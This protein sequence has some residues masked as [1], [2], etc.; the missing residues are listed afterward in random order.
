MKNLFYSFLVLIFIFACLPSDSGGRKP[1]PINC[2]TNAD[3]PKDKICTSKD[4]CAECETTEECSGTLVC[5]NYNCVIPGTNSACSSDSHCASES[6]KKKCHTTLNECVEC[7]YN[8]SGEDTCPN[9][10]ECKVDN[11]CQ[12]ITGGG[13]GVYILGVDCS[14]TTTTPQICRYSNGTTSRICKC[15]FSWESDFSKKWV[16]MG[17]NFCNNANTSLRSK[18]Y[19]CEKGKY[20]NLFNN[21]LRCRNT[22]CYNN[23]DCSFDIQ[24]KQCL[25]SNVCVECTNDNHC[26]NSSKPKCNLDLNTC[27][28]CYDINHCG[29]GQFCDANGNCIAAPADTTIVGTTCLNYNEEKACNY[30]VPSSTYYECKCGLLAS[31]QKWIIKD[32]TYCYRTEPSDHCDSSNKYCCNNTFYCISQQGN[33]SHK[34]Q[35]SQCLK[36]EDCDFDNNLTEC[37]NGTCSIPDPGKELFTNCSD[38]TNTH[39]NCF[40]PNNPNDKTYSCMCDAGKYKINPCTKCKNTSDECRGITTCTGNEGKR[41]CYEE[42]TCNPT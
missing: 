36:N 37:K 6:I 38:Y 28:K 19:W 40:H 34:C 27:V 17:N 33:D 12:T 22:Q 39:N 26:T 11:T 7:I 25:S 30:N 31:N 41:T 23:S 10:K 15:D 2:S 14:I 29:T 16:I 21:E 20:C 1:R 35:N 4:F 24:K 3:C 9:D 5:K 42:L 32:N 18:R 13:G 8:G